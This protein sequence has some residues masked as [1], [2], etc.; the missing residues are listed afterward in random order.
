MDPKVKGGMMGSMA[1]LPD[2]GNLCPSYGLG[3][4]GMPGYTKYFLEYILT[5][6]KNNKIIGLEILHTLV[7][8][9]SVSPKKEM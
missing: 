4:V 6:H 9:K 7:F 5:F 8:W 1:P 2:L 3:A